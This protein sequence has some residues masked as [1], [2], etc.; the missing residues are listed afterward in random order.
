MHSTPDQHTSIGS[1][2]GI[3]RRSVQDEIIETPIRSSAAPIFFN[4]PAPA[5][6][7]D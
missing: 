3:F 2:Q 1:G 6:L 7:G 4:A 5:A